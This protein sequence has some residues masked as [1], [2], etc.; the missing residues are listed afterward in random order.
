MKRRLLNYGMRKISFALIVCMAA[1]SFT[2][3]CGQKDAAA[4]EE[5]EASK[6]IVDVV[7]PVVGDVKSE[8][9]FIGT[10]EYEDETP[11]FSKLSGEVTE[12]FF[13][14]GDYVNAG[15]LLFCLDDAAYK[16]GLAS[17]QAAYDSTEAGMDM[18]LGAL[19]MGRNSDLNTL[20][21]A[22]EG[23]AQIR[24]SYAYYESQYSDLEDNINDLEDDID[25]MDDDKSAAKKK[26]KKAKLALKKAVE[27][28]KAATAA[29]K[30]AL[31]KGVSGNQITLLRMTMDE[32][33]GVVD[34]CSATVQALQGAISGYTTGAETMEGTIDS[35]ESSEKGLNFQKNN[36]NYSYNQAL[37][38]AALAQQNLDY[39]DLYKIPGTER[40]ADATMRQVQAGVDN[41]RLQLEYTQIT[42]P[43]SGTIKTK[44]VDKFGMAQ[45]G[46]P[47]YVITNEDTIQASFKVPESTFRMF[48]MGQEVVIER[49]GTEYSGKIVELDSN[50]DPASGMFKAKAAVNA[51]GDDLTTG[52]TVKIT[53]RT[54][55]AESVLTVP[56]DC[57][58]Y[59][60]GESF[61]Y[62]VENGIVKKKVVEIGIYD[63]STMQII[64]GLGE[65]DE[66]ITVWSSNLR[67][68]LEVEVA[69]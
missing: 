17:A 46:M 65:N 28:A 22:Q 49:N 59:E 3:G 44:S 24:D 42:A 16:I 20:K 45:A 8:G 50:V 37:R 2:T 56:V 25:E 26:L 29:Y 67:D 34:T 7:K 60:S 61:V 38:G 1:A 64:G 55:H 68:G 41:A 15:D 30:E 6:L 11:V 36:L 53:T 10:L 52:T 62:T 9:E 43:V 58:Y 57:V 39:D 40:T 13:E 31:K 21:T 35:L 4:K 54:K 66:V 63:D 12:T 27:A 33:N 51:S 23:A 18:Q 19:A 14:E 32:A 48:T 47:A 5:T 69:K